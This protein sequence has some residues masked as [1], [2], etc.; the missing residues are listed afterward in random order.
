ML[1]LLLLALYV[2]GSEVGIVPILDTVKSVFNR[3]LLRE[4]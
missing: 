3:P 2:C 4:S 1:M